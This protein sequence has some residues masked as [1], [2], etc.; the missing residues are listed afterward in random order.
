MS[1]KHARSRFSNA[2]VIGNNGRPKLANL[3][4][5]DSIDVRALKALGVHNNLTPQDLR[6]LLGCSLGQ[7]YKRLT[8]MMAYPNGLV[9]LSEEQ[10]DY[11]VVSK[12]R[13]FFPT[14]KAIQ[15]LRDAGETASSRRVGRGYQSHA[16]LVSH[17]T[18]SLSAGASQTADFAFLPPDIVRSHA[19]FRQPAEESRF[20]PEIPHSKK[21][22]IVPDTDFVG[23][24]HGSRFRYLVIEADNG[25][26][27]SGET[28]WPTNPEAYKGTSIYEKY[29]GYLPFIEGADSEGLR[30]GFRRKPDSVPMIADSR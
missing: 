13:L 18:A 3:E 1:T 22:R 7:L 27:D 14:H 25:T 19:K 20:H 2:A 21:G 17:C 16:N 23:I 26:D 12:R 11:K 28:I 10:L 6:A 30:T 9:R 24:Q 15:W 5:P 8:I 29:E 4:E